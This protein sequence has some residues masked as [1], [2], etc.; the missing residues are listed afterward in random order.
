LLT[1]LVEGDGQP[2][3]A[4]TRALGHRG[5]RSGGYPRQR[6]NGGVIVPAGTLGDS[7]N[8][9]WI[10]LVH[11][12]R[13]YPDNREETG[14]SAP[15]LESLELTRVLRPAAV[16][17]PLEVEQVIAALRARDVG[18]GGVWSASP[19]AWQR[20]DT[21]WDEPGGTPG[22]AKLVGT[23]V[24][25]YGTPVRGDIAI[26]RVTVTPHGHELGWTVDSLCNDVLGYAGVTLDS[27]ARAAEAS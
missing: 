14:M 17:R 11:A 10:G 20:Y 5:R 12:S 13:T 23:I 15:D 22:S 26:T 27:C 18:V 7:P 6:P 1:T 25:A 19:G 8:R 9:P 24:M 21:A 16:L 4:S 3:F 2:I